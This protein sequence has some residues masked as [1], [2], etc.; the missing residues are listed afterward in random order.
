M[1]NPASKNTGIPTTSPV[2]PNAQAAFLSP[3]LLTN[4]LA[5]VSAPPEHSNIAPNIE[6]RPISNAMLDKV[7]PTPFSIV[8]TIS[9]SGIPD[10]TPIVIALNTI[11]IT[12]CNLPLIINSKSKI[13]PMAAAIISLSG[14]ATN[15]S[16]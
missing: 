9:L 1:I 10:K 5:I 7:F 12:G 3:N 6:P 14:D 16:I 8:K 4:V 11:A 13:I 15:P 2:I